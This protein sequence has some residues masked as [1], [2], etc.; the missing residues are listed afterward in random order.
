MP[1]PIKPADLVG[2]AIGCDPRSLSEDSEMYRT[3]GWDSFGHLNVLLALE[4]E[5]GITVDD[6]AVDVYR[7]MHGIRRRYEA[8]REGLITQ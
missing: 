7:T 6:D 3:F 4:R 8:L 1:E 5:Y 2:T